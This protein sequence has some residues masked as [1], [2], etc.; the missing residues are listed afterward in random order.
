MMETGEIL[1]ELTE[2]ARRRP[3][4]RKALLE[5]ADSDRPLSELCRISKELGYPLYE[6][7]L[8]S[9]GEDYY[10]AMRRSTNGGGENSPHLNWEEEIFGALVDELKK[11]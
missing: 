8:I 6:M 9:A 11:L 3:E 5:T 7:D 2:L 1:M 10:A 4:I